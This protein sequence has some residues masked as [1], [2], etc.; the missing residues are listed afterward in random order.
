M[1]L[2]SREF[3]KILSPKARKICLQTSWKWFNNRSYNE[4]C[5]CSSWC[6]CQEIFKPLAKK[7][8]DAGI[9][10]AGDRP[11]KAGANKIIDA[12]SKRLQAAASE[13]SGDVIRKSLL[14]VQT[15]AK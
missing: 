13:K 4:T 15:A 14:G 2:K 8:L 6:C 12:G 11:G 9:K 5:S 3:K 10:Q 7:P 1:H